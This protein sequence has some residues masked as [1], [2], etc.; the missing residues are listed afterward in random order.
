MLRPGIKADCIGPTIFA[1]MGFNLFTKIRLIILYNSFVSNGRN[2][3]GEQAFSLLGT[4][5][6]NVLFSCFSI[7]PCLKEI[8][9]ALT[10]IFPYNWPTNLKEMCI[11]PIK[12]RCFIWTGMLYSFLN[13]RTSDWFQ[14][15][16]SVFL[17][18]ISMWCNMSK[19]RKKT[20]TLWSQDILKMRD[21]G[22]GNTWMFSIKVT[23]HIS[24]MRNV[25]LTLSFPHKA[26]EILGITITQINSQISRALLVHT[27]FIL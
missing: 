20:I 11:K 23:F 8:H 16:S 13:L 19:I 6:I 21:K 14:Q 9:D 22:G 1:I 7:Y 24:N 10:H 5:T 4:S 2:L 26:I 12:S 15:T 3:S 18:N 17:I 25:R 27:F